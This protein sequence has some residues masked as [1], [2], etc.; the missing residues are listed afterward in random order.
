MVP[1]ILAGASLLVSAM[2]SQYER[3]NG[4]SA[5]DAGEYNA[6]VAEAEA[7]QKQL[8]TTE[9][10]RRMKTQA[11][12]FSSRQK[13]QYAKGG[14][15]SNTGTPLEVMSETVGLMELQAQ[16]MARAGRANVSR[17]KAGATLSRLQG[18]NQRDAA[19]AQSNATLLSGAINAGS[20][21]YGMTRG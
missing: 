12:A 21:Y 16:E 5:A 15:V 7:L 1:L 13:M 11:K 18:N 20:A 9:N 10:Y 8:E 14:V 6:K 3:D 4:K 2:Q 17:L 19:Y